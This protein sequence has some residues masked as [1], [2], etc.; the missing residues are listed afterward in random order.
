[1]NIDTLTRMVN[2]IANYFAAEP[3]HAAGVAGVA[4]HLKKFWDPVMRK[5]IIEHLHAGG[6]GLEPLAREAVQKLASLSSAA[7]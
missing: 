1:M 3:D 5:Q 2:D 6:D 7:A 4:D